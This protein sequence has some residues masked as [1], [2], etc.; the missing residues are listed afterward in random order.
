MDTARQ[1]IVSPVDVPKDTF[2]IGDISMSIAPSSIEIRKEDLVYQYRVLRSK[3]ATK[4]PTG[5]GQVS[6]HLS[7]PFVVDQLLEFHRLVTEIR[8]SPF[9]YVDNRFVRENIVPDWPYAQQMA[10]TITGLSMSNIPNTTDAWCLELDALW[11]NYF[12]YGHNFLFREDWQT[13]LVRSD[14]DGESVL[15]SFTI[16]WH[17]DSEGKRQYYPNPIEESITN[18]SQSLSQTPGAPAPLN[19]WSVGQARYFDT[20]QQRTIFEMEA[21]HPGAEFDL[22][23]LPGNMR[24]SNIVQQPRHSRIFVRY[25]NF[26]QRDALMNNFGIDIRADVLAW[27]EQH[28]T[29]GLFESLFSVGQDQDGLP[30]VIPL[31]SKKIPRVLRTKWINQMLAFNS[32]I[33]FHFHAF[34]EIRLPQKWT[35]NL[36]NKQNNVIQD[37]FGRIQAAQNLAAIQRG[38]P[39][40]DPRAIPVLGAPFPITSGFGL[41]THPTTGELQQH[42]GVDIGAP[43][44][45]PILAPEQGE[46]V[47]T[48][49]DSKSGNFVKYR[50]ANGV[51]AFCHLDLINIPAGTTEAGVYSISPGTLL[52]TVGNTGRTTAIQPNGTRD[53][54]RGYH[55][56]LSFAPAPS[57]Q[58]VDPLMYLDQILVLQNAANQANDFTSPIAGDQTDASEPFFDYESDPENQ[59]ALTTQDQLIELARQDAQ[60]DLELTQE[61]TDA[62]Q[63]LLGVLASEGWSYYDRDTTVTNIWQKLYTLEIS[64]SGLDLVAGRSEFPEAFR[65]QG[66]V[67]TN[68]SGSLSHIVASI[69]ILSH[70]FPTQQHLGS[71][72]PEYQLEF[73]VLDDQTDL[74][75][76]SGMAQL[77]QGMRSM[78]QANSRRFRPVLDG[79]CVATDTFITRFFG[80]YKQNDLRTLVID[81]YTADA[82]LK[83]RTIISNTY[84]G[85][86]SGNPGLSTIAMNLQETNPYETEELVSTSPALADKEASRGEVLRATRNLELAPQYKDLMAPLFLAQ[87]L[88]ANLT[89][90]DSPDFGKFSIRTSNLS[91]TAIMGNPADVFLYTGDGEQQL[92]VRQSSPNDLNMLR[93]LGIEA[94][95]FAPDDRETGFIKLDPNQMDGLAIGEIDYS[96]TAGVLQTGFGNRASVLTGGPTGIGSYTGQPVDPSVLE[97]ERF[98]VTG[99]DS[100]V[101]PTANLYDVSSL[102]QQNPALAQMPVQ[103]FM[104]YY[105]A[106]LAYIGTGNKMFSESEVG[107]LDKAFVLNELYQLPFRQDMWKSWQMYLEEFC[108]VS[109]VTSSTTALTELHSN[110]AWPRP[111]AKFWTDP[112][113]E[114]D[115]YAAAVLAQKGFGTAQS[116]TGWLYDVVVTDVGKIIFNPVVAAVSSQYSVTDSFPDAHED[117]INRL[118]SRYMLGFPIQVWLPD[119]LKQEYQFVLGDIFGSAFGSGLGKTP[120]LDYIADDLIANADSCGSIT[121]DFRG[122]LQSQNPVW[123]SEERLVQTGILNAVGYIPDF[124]FGKKPGSPFEYPVNQGFEQ[125][126]VRYIKGLLA[127]LADDILGDYRMLQMLGLEHLMFLDEGRDYAGKAC[128]PDLDL[129]AHPYYSTNTQ[130]YPDFYMWNIYEDGGA[131]GPDQLEAIQEQVEFIVENSY[132]A[133]KRMSQPQRYDERAEQQVPELSVDNPLVI[134]TRMTPE[135][136]DAQADGTGH[137]DTPFAPSKAAQ[138]AIE[139]WSKDVSDGDWGPKL[140]SSKPSDQMD[141]IRLANTEGLFGSHASRQYL[142]RTDDTHY[143]ILKDQFAKTTHLFGSSEGYMNRELNAKNTPSVFDAVQGTRLERPPEAAHNFDLTSLKQLAKDSSKDLISQKMTMKRAFPTF[144][145][146][147]VEEDEFETRFLNFDD[148]YSY[149]AVKEISVVQSRKIA[150]DHAI[151]TLQ[152]ISGTLD[153]TRRNSI[154]DLDYFT[155]PNSVSV[156]KKKVDAHDD[157][158]SSLIDGDPITAGTSSEQPFGSVVLRPGLNVQLRMGYSNDPNS[159]HVMI[160]GR[161]VDVTW[162]TTGDLAEILIQSFGAELD[163]V[164]KGTER[165]GGRVFATTHELLG[166]LMLEPEVVHFGRW[167]FGQQFQVG[168]AKDFRLDFT[169]YSREGYMGKFTIT[170]WLSQWIMNHPKMTLAIGVALTAANLFPFGR[171]FGAA[172]KGLSKI[173]GLARIAPGIAEAG[174]TRA[175]GKAGYTALF[176]GVDDVGRTAA[177]NTAVRGLGSQAAA[178]IKGFGTVGGKQFEQVLSSRAAIAL[179]EFGEAATPE[180][181]GVALAKLESFIQ[182]T[183]FKGKWMSKP[184]IELSGATFLTGVG[185]KPLGT[186]L[187]LSVGVPFRVGGSVFIAAGLTDLVISKLLTPIYDATVG[188]ARKFFARTNATMF[189]TPQD[190]NLYPPHPKD[191]M[192][193]DKS[194]FRLWIG[195]P[196]LNAGAALVGA[197]PISVNQFLFPDT[198]L[199]KKVDP[200]D[201]QYQLVSTS[202]WNVF[203]EMTLRHP[204]WVF[205][206]RPYGNK[207]QYTMFFGL[208][209][210]RYW[211][212]PATNGFITRAND[213]YRFLNSEI[214]GSSDQQL[215]NEFEFRTLYGDDVFS[216]LQEQVFA[217]EEACNTQVFNPSQGFTTNSRTTNALQTQMTAVALAE[218]LRAVQIRFEPFRRYHL[219]TSERDIVWNGIMGSE[220]AVI[221]AVDVT[222]FP[223]TGD[224]TDPENSQIQTAVFKAHSFIPESKLRIAPVRWY[225][226]LGYGM[227]Q[228]YAMGEL[229]DR[230]RDMYRGEFIILGNP[231]VRPLDVGIIVDSYNSMV[232][233]IEVEQ[234]VH[235]Y[236]HET[237]YLTEIKP[238]AVVYANEISGWPLLE[239]MKTFSLAIQDIHSRYAGVKADNGEAGPGSLATATQILAGLPGLGGLT[240]GSSR[241][242]SFIDERYRKIFGESGAQIKDMWGSEPPPDFALAEGV[243]GDI[244]DTALDVATGVGVVGASA[245]LV[246]GVGVLQAL[247]GVEGGGAGS[248]VKAF[249]KKP[250]GLAYG[251]AFIAGLGGLSAFGAPLILSQIDFP[252]LAFLLGANVLFMQCL[253]NDAIILVPLTKSGTP[254]VA[255]LTFN[256]PALMWKSFRGMLER[257]FTESLQGTGNMLDLYKR[258]GSEIW[259]RLSDQD[260]G[261]TAGSAVSS[262][263]LGGRTNIGQ[264]GNPS[265]ISGLTGE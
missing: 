101:Y 179:K 208:P 181:S 258:Y 116:N 8:N 56:H 229:C 261:A 59:I 5:S 243:V 92:L 126:K 158:T 87:K 108:K 176:T 164:I 180:A 60:E 113:P 129:P 79:W 200:N 232:G 4:V 80:S 145:L 253:R 212:R 218:Y 38:D 41:R 174:S 217:L 172:S 146:Y 226:C 183:V 86:V 123:N 205:G 256:D 184:W 106:L 114:S 37:L 46:V 54:T 264:S 2:V 165:N 148:F 26:L 153:G 65:N 140:S 13:N 72:E 255:G 244:Y 98:Q 161:V 249:A 134:T 102:L 214:A 203:H 195:D 67:L 109:F 139:Q 239:A 111:E 202:I 43:R 223:S 69:P 120:A 159:L 135:G 238:S 105:V 242:D 115:R 99:T 257:S 254:I 49:Y 76:I 189:L 27:E 227:A 173:P 209:A 213:L 225:N 17:L 171:V 231:R 45:T 40:G 19:K 91:P 219:F 112:I 44:G 127:A 97:S 198:L 204:G 177:F 133:M 50:T 107:G 143:A 152:N 241:Y 128:Y 61:E 132:N 95:Y 1:T 66:I 118:V 82:D 25:H 234:V 117:A 162:N 215:I 89:N 142:A 151:I 74:E 210:Q 103:K 124:T 259:T 147:F 30:I 154:V 221:N 57:D 157:T 190:D 20:N 110:P 39:N 131:L 84:E 245:T 29:T 193:L 122:V 224:R 211:A 250:M 23:P 81:G 263:W 78:L 85:T 196:V 170:S 32:G 199:S 58:P 194:R 150:A 228:R 141:G 71:I 137:M 206:T 9:V 246:G 52:G 149:N 156:A 93:S 248:I 47:Q 233:P 63:D 167:E 24:P 182:T 191:Y 51:W 70:E 16:G 15:Q 247:K 230:M 237:G 77:V 22:L 235:T 94:D 144:K 168:E 207:Y 14:S 240:G 100:F 265:I 222:Y 33:R 160:S 175:I 28:N 236:S 62:L 138:P 252:G 119:W 90:P 201:C 187:N 3:V 64:N 186:L 21:S 68:V 197:D 96:Q 185:A 104:D 73:A 251:A 31:H 10:F 35:D 34:K 11:F 178:A 48:G 42:N 220:N 169:E 83:K 18:G 88:G 53:E 7:I 216:Q 125:V 136:T 121:F 36:A 75:G 166:S 130:V 192:T 260:L 12:P 262:G 6:I 188:G 163:Q 55:L 155:D